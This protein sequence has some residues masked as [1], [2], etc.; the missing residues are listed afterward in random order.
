MTAEQRGIVFA[1]SASKSLLSG[2]QRQLLHAPVRQL[3]NQQFVLV[4][5]VDRVD[6]PEL[7][8]QL[9]CA[10][11]L[12]DDVAVEIELVNRRVFHAVRIPGVRDIQILS[13]AGR[14]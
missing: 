13:R 5:A 11:E 4:A 1:R 6:E 14:D 3:A 2:S 9:A 10:A 7:L 12:S 8:R